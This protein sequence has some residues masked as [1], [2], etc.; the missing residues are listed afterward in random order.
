[1]RSS[2]RRRFKAITASACNWTASFTR[3]RAAGHT[4]SR[5]ASSALAFARFENGLLLSLGVGEFAL[6]LGHESHEALF[7]L[8]DRWHGLCFHFVPPPGREESA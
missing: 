2:P 6:P 1:V 4:A 3:S 5:L 8:G 7:F